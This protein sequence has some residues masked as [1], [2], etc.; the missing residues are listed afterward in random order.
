MHLLSAHFLSF[1]LA[2]IML[3]GSLFA[4][5]PSTPL[6]GT[7]TGPVACT[8]EAKLCPDGSYVGRS[9]PQC[10]FAECPPVV[11]TTTPHTVVSIGSLAPRSGVVGTSVTIRGSGFTSDNTILFGS[12]VVIHVPSKN[13][14]SLTFEVPNGLTPACFYST[15]RCLVATRMTT[16]G[17][18]AVSVR[19]AHGTSNAI[20]FTVTETASTPTP[21]TI[22]VQSVSPT[23]GQVGTEV[24]LT[25]RFLSDS[26]I[27]HFGA[28]AIG[29]VK[30]TSSIAVAC[31]TDPACIPGIRQ[32]I[33]F[34]VP[35][36]VGPYCKAGMMCP[37]YMQLVTSGVY[38]VSVENE[39]GI[40]NAV[41][42]S[43]VGNSALE[44]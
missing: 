42:F 44:L 19:N 27:I 32:T 22:S 31:T 33:T 23:S 26:N 30:I 40:S 3:F 9:G 34:T 5:A 35:S 15:P 8:M 18:Y 25:G 11:A 39:N 10:A 20:T 6:V 43:V 38:K 7:T 36:S 41:D 37:M 12:G 1:F 24:T 28:G 14:T 4:H 16:P 29:P 2:L 21:A 17:D 13:G